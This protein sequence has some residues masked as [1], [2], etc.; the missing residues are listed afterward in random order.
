VTD[1][2][3]AAVAAIERADDADAIEHLLAAWNDQRA[4]PIARVIELV[5]LCASGLAAM[6]TEPGAGDASALLS[7]SSL[8]RGAVL[9]RLAHSS[10]ELAEPE[11]WLQAL[12][13]LPPDPRVTAMLQDLGNRVPLRWHADDD[14]H[15][16]DEPDMDLGDPVTHRFREVCRHHADHRIANVPHGDPALAPP[17]VS[18][19]GRTERALFDAEQVLRRRLFDDDADR[20]AAAALIANPDDDA[21]RFAYADWL[22]RRGDLRGD[23]LR[24]GK[25]DDIRGW[26]EWDLRALWLGPVGRVAFA[27]VDTGIVRALRF[28]DDRRGESAHFDWRALDVGWRPGWS[29]VREIDWAPGSLL[30]S[31]AL[32]ALRVLGCRRDQLDIALAAGASLPD[33]DALALSRWYGDRPTT[34]D[35]RHLQTVLRTP[36][37]RGVRRLELYAYAK[38]KAGMDHA[39]DALVPLLRD[40]CGVPALRVNLSAHDWSWVPSARWLRTLRDTASPLRQFRAGGDAGERWIFGHRSPTGVDWD[41]IRVEWWANDPNPFSADRVLEVADAGARSIRVVARHP[42]R[43]RLAEQLRRL[44]GAVT[45]EIDPSLDLDRLGK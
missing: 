8:E 42:V 41:D 45:I 7:A 28:D 2:V 25:I 10:G 40:P 37:L 44:G 38:S 31:V 4:A 24:D 30:S 34:D 22:S 6:T 3:A 27:R 5:D 39:I 36:A 23:V 21:A 35:A 32:P 11:A 26:P 33:L 29:A 1:H 18:L 20:A 15:D 19:D 12:H 16:L 13:R 9:R 17:D 43:G 14:L